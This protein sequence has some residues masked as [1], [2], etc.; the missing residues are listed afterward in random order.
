MCCLQLGVRELVAGALDINGAS[1]RRFFFEVLARFA[2]SEGEA[3]RL[4]YFVTLEGRDDLYRYNQREGEHLPLNLHC[5]CYSCG[6]PHSAPLCLPRE[7]S[8]LAQNSRHADK[9]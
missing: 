5:A 2:T 3:E 9:L 8:M 4:Q 1:P 6:K 7:P